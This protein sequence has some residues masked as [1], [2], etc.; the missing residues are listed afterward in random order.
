MKQIVECMVE[1]GGVINPTFKPSLLGST[2]HG[3]GDYTSGYLKYFHGLE[4]KR[5]RITIEVLENDQGYTRE[6]WLTMLSSAQAMG[7]RGVDL[8]KTDKSIKRNPA[9]QDLINEGLVVRD[10]LPMGHN[11]IIRRVR[12]V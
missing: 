3:V 8:N 2:K 1:D 11:W 6:E 10:D 9:L 12:F 5:V 4:G 7:H